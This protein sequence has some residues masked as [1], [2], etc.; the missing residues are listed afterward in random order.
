MKS[1]LT[2]PKGGVHPPEAKAQTASLAIERM[3]VPDELEIILGQHIGAPCAATVNKRD[4]VSEG[5]LIGDV[6]RGLGVPLHAPAK[7][8]IKAVGSSAHPMRV[9]SPS[10]TIEVD[11]DAQAVL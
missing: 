11:H 5:A 2:F 6:K 3:A 1:L 4:E 10:V 7:G 9:S 8:K